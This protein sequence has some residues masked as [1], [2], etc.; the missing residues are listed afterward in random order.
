MYGL[1][2]YH[3]VL[4]R[5]PKG[6]ATSIA[7]APRSAFSVGKGLCMQNHASSQVDRGDRC[8]AN[9]ASSAALCVTT[10]YPSHSEL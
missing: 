8:E 2:A 6:V 4:K 10:L 7:R 1:H 3:Q 5:D 9:V